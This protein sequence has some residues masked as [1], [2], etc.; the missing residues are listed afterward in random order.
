MKKLESWSG[1]NDDEEFDEDYDDYEGFDAEDTLA[2][3]KAKGKKFADSSNKEK[4]LVDFLDRHTK[5][6]L[7]ELI[8]QLTKTYPDYIHSEKSRYVISHTYSPLACLKNL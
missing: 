3:K 8:L 4:E 2:G 6:S 1:E 5:E 7:K